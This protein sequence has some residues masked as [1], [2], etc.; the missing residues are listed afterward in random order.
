MRNDTQASPVVKTKTIWCARDI[1]SLMPTRGTWLLSRLSPSTNSGGMYGIIFNGDSVIVFDE[2]QIEFSVSNL[3]K[4]LSAKS[5]YPYVFSGPFQSIKDAW[6]FAFE[7]GNQA[8]LAL[9]NSKKGLTGEAGEK[10]TDST[11]IWKYVAVAVGALTIAALAFGKPQP[12]QP[13]L[14]NG[15]PPKQ[16]RRNSPTNKNSTYR[17]EQI[18]VEDLKKKVLLHLKSNISQFYYSFRYAY[19]GSSFIGVRSD[20]FNIGNIDKTILTPIL[21]HLS[22]TMEDRETRQ[23]ICLE[24]SWIYMET[25]DFKDTFF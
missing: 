12:N 18:D 8:N 21:E 9:A 25:K 13:M 6:T 22:A 24:M 20:D 1:E 5:G 16:V 3:K 15:I 4:D 10:K 23:V 2:N 19:E 14:Q 17:G 7:N 11:S